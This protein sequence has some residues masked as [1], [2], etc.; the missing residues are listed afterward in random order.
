VYFAFKNRKYFSCFLGFIIVFTSI[1]FAFAE[2]SLDI[3][4]KSAILM[5]FST[6]DILYENNSDEKLPPASI[7]KIMVLLIAM[8]SIEK[9]VI[10]L[11]DE[12][13]V[14][15]N[16]AGMGGSQVYLEEGEI[17]TVESLL[18]AICLRSANDASVA[19][20]EHIS[21]SEEIFAKRMNER[22][23]QLGMKNT[24]F[25]NV[26]GL[27]SEDH[28]TTAHDIALMSREL[29]KHPK[30]HGWL[31]L[32][33]AEIKVGKNKDVVQGLV[34]TNRLVKEYEGANGVKTGF[35][36]EAGFCLSGSAKRGNL[37]LISVIMGCET[38]KLR[39][40]ETKRMLDYGFATYDSVTIGKKDDVVGKV[41]VEKGKQREVNVVFEKDAFVLLPKGSQSN[42]EREYILPNSLLAPIEKNSKLGELVITLDGKVIER[43]N[44]VSSEAVE[45]ANFGDMFKVLFN[46]LIHK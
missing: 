24:N 16:A 13:V 17:Q 3:K 25:K 46:N 20:A 38:S 14:T 4:G 31:T 33:M 18:K 35:T 32:W 15:S 6:G 44:L 40:E 28:Y 1:N 22:A 7:T 39:F 5:D 34:N 41:I 9:G 29:L 2:P 36:N 11:T 26:T 19:L 42:L 27:P 45:R 8:E 23:T 10:K 37:Q 43:I 12:V 21:G 30:I